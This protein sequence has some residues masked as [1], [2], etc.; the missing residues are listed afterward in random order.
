MTYRILL[1]S[2]EA[3]PS[4]NPEAFQVGKVC[5]ALRS[6][7]NFVVDLATAKLQSASGDNLISSLPLWQDTT[8]CQEITISC[9][10]PRWQRA[11]I[12]LLVPGLANR[13]D[14]WFLFV[15]RWRQIV[16]Q[17]KHPPD[18][19]YSRSFPLSS[20]L[21]AARLSEHYGVP[22][23]LHLSDPWTEASI[24]PEQFSS[25][26][27]K[28][29]EKLCL[30]SAHRISFSSPIT[31]GRYQESYP[32]LQDRMK[33]DPNCYESSNI[34]C[35]VWQPGLRFRVVHTGSFTLPRRPDLIV[36]S[37]RALPSSSP[38]LGDI[39]LMQAGVLDEHARQQFRKINHLCGNIAVLPFNESLMLQR[40]ADVLLAVDS[41]FSCS[42]DSQYLPSKLTDY[43]AIR[44][45]VIVI[46]NKDSAS[47]NFVIENR[48]GIPVA[49]GDCAGLTTA[50]LKCWQAWHQGDRTF[51]ELP[52]PNLFYS[53]HA[54]A[55]KIATAA[56][57]I[58]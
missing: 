29:Q 15:W 51:F 5:E 17:L 19:I 13:P 30:E 58:L 27:H 41:E 28:R 37:L 3:P 31:L 7:P 16:S 26:W 10:L 24:R 55:K 14:W 36:R 47:W 6:E 25:P 53:S 45:P 46:T 9:R 56:R 12:R 40:S 44:R 34:S 43:L 1:V 2:V 8:V 11:F 49:H 57:E 23:F 21:A 35:D 54:V 32:Y 22:W 48:L 4:F 50:F 38:L 52:Y 42:R 18:L 33:L 20:T 39:E